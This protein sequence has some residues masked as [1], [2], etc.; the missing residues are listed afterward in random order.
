MRHVELGTPS[1]ATYRIGKRVYYW[2]MVMAEAH[3]HTV[4][5]LGNERVDRKVL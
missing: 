4:Y 1:V 2:G 3:A 5:N